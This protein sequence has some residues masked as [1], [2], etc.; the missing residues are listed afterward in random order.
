MASSTSETQA[1]AISSS[2]LFRTLGA[3]S[4][5]SIT[6]LII[7]DSLR[8]I[9]HDRLRGHDNIDQIVEGVRKSLEYLADLD[10]AIV[11][12]VREAYGKAIS[13]GFIFPA[14]L[15]VCAFASSLF[16]PRKRP[17]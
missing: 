11:T 14:A 4:G 15:G 3:I 9:L 5:V 1:F 13:L 16:L 17:Q 6:S 8:S 12:I 10:P 2:Y 7:Q